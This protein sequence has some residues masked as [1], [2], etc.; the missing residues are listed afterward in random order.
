MKKFTALFFVAGFLVLTAITAQANMNFDVDKKTDELKTQLN[1]TDDQVDQVKP[2]LEE[3]KDK[4]KQA[5]DEKMD[6]LKAI[7]NDDQDK[8][9]D[10]WVK[11]QEKK[12]EKAEKE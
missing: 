8:K 12:M 1:L 2:V 9:L 6:K 11:D 3:F 10:Q 7:L 4:V 5:H